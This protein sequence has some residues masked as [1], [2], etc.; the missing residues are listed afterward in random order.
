LAGR[1]GY[2]IIMKLK[3]GVGRLFNKA[4]RNKGGGQLKQVKRRQIEI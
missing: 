3:A 1:R 4:K 2:D